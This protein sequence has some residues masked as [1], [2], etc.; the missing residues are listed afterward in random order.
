[1]KPTNNKNTTKK[2]AIEFIQDIEPINFSNELLEIENKLAELNDYNFQFSFGSDEDIKR[3]LSELLEESDFYNI[4]I[5]ND[6]G[7]YWSG[8]LFEYPFSELNQAEETVLNMIKN[9]FLFIDDSNEG[10]KLSFKNNSKSKLYKFFY[11]YR[12]GAGEN[13][14]TAIN[15]MMR[16]LKKWMLE[17]INKNPDSYGTWY[18]EITKICSG[19]GETFSSFEES[20]LKKCE[21]CGE[22]LVFQDEYD[23]FFAEEE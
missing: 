11:K 19:C 14:P 21:S 10:I 8:I 18:E 3:I 20:E 16:K 2:S 13:I 4:D 23:Q 6:Y 15:N 17:K 22:D 9:D 5:V 1:M 7:F 12:D